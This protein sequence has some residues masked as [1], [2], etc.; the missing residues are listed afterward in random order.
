MAIKNEDIWRGIDRLADFSG[1]SVSGMARKAGLDPTT[2]NPSK[3]LGPDGKQ[4]W[5]TTESI[6]KILDATEVSIGQFASLMFEQPTGAVSFPLQTIGAA[7]ASGEFMF[8][9]DGFPMGTD[10]G[11]RAFPNLPDAQAFGI[12]IED[13]N[14]APIIRAGDLIVAAPGVSIRR[15]D[16]VLVKMRHG[17][18]LLIR[19]LIRQT[20]HRA[21]FASL[22]AAPTEE[23]M[24]AEIEWM[25][26]IVWISQ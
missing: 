25:S 21:E 2:F 15:G 4:R 19:A 17:G 10:W 3:R 14:L 23:V 5:P 7:E 16:R 22:V 20:A 18:P 13:D 11:S 8:D 1:Q 12:E 24:S 6:A 26:R 9:E